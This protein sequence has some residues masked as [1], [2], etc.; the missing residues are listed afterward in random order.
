MHTRFRMANTAHDST[1][2]ACEMKILAI[3]AYTPM[4]DRSTGDLRFSE[5][6]KALAREHTVMFCAYDTIDWL[7]ESEMNPYRSALVDSGITVCGKDPIAAIKLVPY[8]AILFEFY[9]T[10]RSYIDEARFWQP[11]ARVLIDSVDVHFNRL[12][13]K[14]RLTKTTKDYSKARQ[15]K[16]RELTTY[17]KADVVTTVSEEDRKILQRE[18]RDLRVEI[19]PLIQEVPPLT[20]TARQ[21]SSSLLFVGN[22]HHHPNVDAM[23]YFCKE[24]LPLIRHEAPDVRLTI[25]GNSPPEAVKSLAGDAVSVFGYVPDLKPLLQGSDISIA[26][27]RYGGGIKGKISEAMAHGLPVVTTSVGTEGFGLSPGENV[28][29]GDTPTAFADAVVQ[30]IRDR[31]LCDKLRKAAW[32]FVNERYSVSA[33]SKQIQHVFGTLES[34]PV[35]RLSRAKIITKAV[36]YHLARYVFWRFKQAKAKA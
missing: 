26:P 32:A 2:H 17:R 23:V 34:N 9:Y 15:L 4:P 6:L 30:L 19:I 28:L 7:G 18:V 13:A 24:I 20:E 33:V 21:T 22:F 12:A 3:A 11:T 14:A 31:Q 35:K 29:V 1:K 8:D 25:V 5:M 27:L 10:A 16:S 36:R